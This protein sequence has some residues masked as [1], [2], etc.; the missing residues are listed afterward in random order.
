MSVLAIDICYT[1]N[2]TSWKIVVRNLICADNGQ[3][4]AVALDDNPKAPCSATERRTNHRVMSVPVS[5]L[6]AVT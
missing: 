5:N 2:S 3:T 1:T 4:T 6:D